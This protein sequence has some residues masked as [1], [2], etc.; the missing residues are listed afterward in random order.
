MAVFNFE[1][2]QVAQKS[3]LRDIRKE[4]Q[5]SLEK[6]IIE[7]SNIHLYQM[8]R[9]IFTFIYRRRWKHNHDQYNYVKKLYQFVPVNYILS[10]NILQRSSD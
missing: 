6:E 7:V 2:F 8:F 9:I 1:N 5:Y 4:V 10:Y 3:T